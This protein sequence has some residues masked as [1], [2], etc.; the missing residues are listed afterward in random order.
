[1]LL[2]TLV[3]RSSEEGPSAEDRSDSASSP[4]AAEEKTSRPTQGDGTIR[5]EGI[6]LP[7]AEAA[8]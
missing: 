5:R 8:G 2:R 4:G 6:E 3:S 1:M 7:L